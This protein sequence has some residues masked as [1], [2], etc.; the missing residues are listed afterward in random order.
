MFLI[1]YDT[2]TDDAATMRGF[3]PKLVDVHR[4]H[5]IPATLFC[6]GRMLEKRLDEFRDFAAEIRN[7]PL[8]EVQD[9]SYSHIGVGYENGAPV[10]VLRADYARSFDVHEKVFGRRPTAVSLCG[11]GG[12]DGPRLR[13]FDQTGKALAEL[14]MLAELGVR[15]VNTFRTDCAEDRVFCEYADLGHPEV[16]GF[17]SG[18]SDTS[19]MLEKTSDWKWRRREPFGEAVTSIVDEIARR[20]KEGTHMPLMLHDWA[21]WTLAPDRELDSVKRFADAARSAGFELV[22]HAEGCRRFGSPT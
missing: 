18:F 17:P 21:A 7:D 11:T 15:R 22:T 8:F 1:R 5:R 9:H 14:A 6:T 4:R 13:G 10:E 2:E 16:S 3:L 12:K 19:W 20:G